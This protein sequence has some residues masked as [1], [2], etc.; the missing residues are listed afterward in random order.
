MRLTS[1]LLAL[2]LLW[3]YR[4]ARAAVALVGLA[5]WL[6]DG[7]AALIV[8]LAAAARLHWV[9]RVAAGLTLLLLWRWPWW[10]ALPL[11]VPRLPLV[12]PGLINTGL[13][14]VR[15]PRPRWP[16]PGARVGS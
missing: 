14:R 8:A 16:A 4:L 12:L 9:L 5:A 2:A 6:G 1:G 3:A 13:A 11:A 10:V 15:H 7:W